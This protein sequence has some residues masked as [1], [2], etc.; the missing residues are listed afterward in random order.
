MKYRFRIYRAAVLLMILALL[1]V[2]VCSGAEGND[3]GAL[4]AGYG[5]GNQRVSGDARGLRAGQGQSDDLA[6]FLDSIDITGAVLNPDGQYVIVDG[7]PYSIRMHFSE[8]IN[9]LQFD[10]GSA[11]TYDF[12]G[13]FTPQ[14][15][16]GRFEMTGNGGPVW[17]DYVIRGNRL[18]VTFDQTSPG[19]P[20]FIN[21]EDAQFEILATG[22]IRESVIEFSSEV[23]GEFEIDD[24]HEV[25]VR[26][27]GEYDGVLN[28]IKFT[29]QAYSRGNNTNVHIGDIISGTALTYDADSL[30]VSS[31]KNNPV[32]YNADTRE[33][34]TFGLTLPF[35]VPEET[36][37]V[38]YYANVDLDHLTET[39]NRIYGTI[40]ETKNEV[41]IESDNNPPPP[42]IIIYNDDFQHKITLSTN[43]KTASAQVVRDGKTYVTWTIVLNENANISIAGSTI[44]D[45][46]DD[47]SREVMRYSGS[48]IHIERYQ[49]DG[50][51]AGASDIQWGT[52]G[53]SASQGGSSW[54][55]TI[56]DSDAEKKYRY[57]ITY[58]TE[59]D[60][61][62]FLQSTTVANKVEND[63]D[64]DYGGAIVD[65]TGVEVE[66][67]KS[68][69][70]STVDHEHKTART[71][72][73]LT[74]T[75]P[76]AG[77]DSAV[78]I[79]SL[80]GFLDYVENRWF[81]DTYL[82][83]SAHVKEGDLLDGEDF[84]V[85][86]N[87]EDHQVVI[88]FSKNA[89][90]PGLRGTGL[91]RTIH[92][93][94]TTEAHPDWLEYAESDARAR[95]HVNNAVVRLNG[96]DIH[97][98]SSTSYNTTNYDLEKL[99]GG[100]YS[101]NT[102]PALPIYLYKIT[103]TGVNDDTFDPD[104][105]LT[106]TD[107]YDSE[108]L[109][110]LPSYQTNEDRSVNSPNGH[111]YGNNQWNHDSLMDANKGPYVVDP[112]SSEGQLVFKLDKNDIPKALDGSYWYYYTI[113]YALQVKDAETLARMKEEALHSDGL[114]VE[115]KNIASSDRF[116]THEIVTE[117]TI[118]ALT[119]TMQWEHDT[120]ATGT[121]DIHFSIDVNPEGLKIG[122]GNTI[123][124]KDTISNLSFDYTSIEIRPQLEGD[125]LN[126]IGNSIVFTLQNETPYTIEYTAR[127]I[128]MTDNVHW[129]NKADLYGYVSGV[130]GESDAYSSGF[131][132]Y[133]TFS[134][135]ILKYA[136]GNMNHGLGATFELYEAR[137]KDENGNDIPNPRWS[138]VIPSFTTD[139][140]T[141][142]AKITAVSH[143]GQTEAQSLRPYSYHDADG[144]ERFGTAGS[145]AYGWRYRVREIVPPEGYQGADVEYE[146]GISD[147]PSYVAPYNYLNDDTVTIV[148]KP[149]GDVEIT[150]PGNKV[151]VGKELKAQEF[152]FSLRPED[153]AKEAWTAEYPGGFDGS[154]TASNDEEGRFE[155]HLSYT[156]EDYQYAKQHQLLEEDGCVYL[157]YIVREELPE[158][159]VDAVLNGVT[160][161][162]SRF[163]VE[164][165]LYLEG[166]QLKTETRSFPYVGDEDTGGS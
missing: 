157:Y 162:E 130:S 48:G 127:L 161:D 30:V 52:G 35:M 43:S 152:T 137:V 87:P 73:E 155:F 69:S 142:L 6:A 77:L 159:A 133:S 58:E 151:L 160:Y 96:Q 88:S 18:T 26:K 145:E 64:T 128:G 9:G 125:T 154:L 33:G 12:P 40:D 85:E 37:T 46:I 147:I 42:P 109:I 31:N 138:L 93:Y 126:R 131:G 107:L 1:T 23:T 67:S 95:T 76:P 156:Y 56:P 72:W 117:Y 5:N 101:T 104:G 118:N 63:Y 54:T 20:Y 38:E 120:L 163:L 22:L 10:T 13:G 21:S 11:L 62:A 34:E 105:Y 86:S 108:Y 59:V 165:K 79:D 2:G 28:K 80:P 129:N 146:F 15:T 119:K 134:I 47:L 29:I 116:G 89:G 115:L 50:T 75:V 135:N 24:E 83:N 74:F 71:E 14:D 16:S 92:V 25:T 132:T 82:D 123:T 41:I 140:E 84:A 102:D 39:G 91:T 61:E 148:N 8:K 65:T 97:V 70:Q 121:H 68:V 136:E 66:A 150:V 44:T 112:S 111:V 27:I 45:T 141:G 106:I 153:K 53:L 90:E 17:V 99:Y 100:T 60:S 32:Q 110:Y 36:V 103:L 166:R 4:A 94:L 144:I 19:Y 113:V 78:I 122:D 3:S 49:K 124:V 149:I 51:P 164:V 7:V 139:P 143:E 114:R 57:V 158:G 98:T 55:Y 81:Y